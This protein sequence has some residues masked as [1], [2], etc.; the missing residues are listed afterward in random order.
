MADNELQD[1]IE[2]LEEL[3]E[4]TSV[5]KNVKE[6]FSEMINSLKSSKELSIKVNKALHGLD[7]IG[8]DTNLQPYVRTQIWNLVSMLEKSG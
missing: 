6:K 4:D 8:D 1:V 7:E 5:P 2:V 3:C